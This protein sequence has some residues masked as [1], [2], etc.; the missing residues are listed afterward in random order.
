M[1]VGYVLLAG[2]V[3]VIALR[4]AQDVLRFDFRELF[5]VVCFL[6]ALYADAVRN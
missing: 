3:A 1:R 2:A 4:L 6:A 5:L